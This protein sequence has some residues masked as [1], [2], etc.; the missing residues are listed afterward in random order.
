MTIEQ[1]HL[2]CLEHITAVVAGGGLQ[3]E[4]RFDV[5]QDGH[6]EIERITRTVGSEATERRHR[7][8]KAAGIGTT[9]GQER[10]VQVGSR[11]AGR[12]HTDDLRPALIVAANPK[13]KGLIVQNT[14]TT[15]IK[16]ALGSTVPDQLAYH[17]A[18]KACSTADDG[19]GGVYFDDGWAGPVYGISSAAGGTFV[20][21]EI[22]TGNPD[23]NLASD[24][25]R[26]YPL[27]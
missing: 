5:A 27:G 10:Q 3:Q 26:G 20:L 23:W 24:P 25:G 12:I 18:L 4:K 8:A 15:V 14:G 16:L 9:T 22:T 21:T 1:S 7:Q 6:A 17:I 13:R 19:L 11:L 2:R